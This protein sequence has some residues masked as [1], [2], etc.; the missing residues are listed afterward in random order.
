MCSV[1]GILRITS[2]RRADTEEAVARMN[3]AQ[4]HRGP[5]DRGT[6]QC[7]FANAEISLGNTRLAIIDTSSAGHQP[8]LDAETGNCITY[9][10]EAYNFKI[11]PT[12]LAQIH[13]RG[14]I[15]K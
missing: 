3:T 7:R 6:W 2:V 9:N 14:R 4:Q 1:S 10:G 13:G 15:Q 12:L 5:D 11:C 8:M